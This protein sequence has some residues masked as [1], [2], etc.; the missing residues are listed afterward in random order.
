MKSTDWNNFQNGLKKYTF[1]AQNFVFSDVKGNVGV[2]S[3]GILPYRF[4][5]YRGEMLDGSKGHN[6]TYVPFNNLPQ[7]FESDSGYVYSANQLPVK[8][9]Y[10]INYSWAENFR[11]SR[12]NAILSQTGTL[13]FSEMK[14]IHTDK[15]DNSFFDIIKLYDSISFDNKREEWFQELRSWNG[16][17]SEES[18]IALK[19][20]MLSLSLEHYFS[21]HFKNKD[22]TRTPS[23]HHVIKF[24]GQ[25]KLKLNDEIITTEIIKRAVVDSAI[26]MHEEYV[27]EDMDY[28]NFSPFFLNHIL[29]IPGLGEIV[30][31]KG[32][33][34]NTI[35][36][37][38]YSEH[39]ASMRTI[40]ELS[41]DSIFIETILAGGQ[42]GRVNSPNYSSQ[43]RMWKDGKYNK[44][45]FR[46]TVKNKVN[47]SFK[48]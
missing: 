35:D 15:I 27:L 24:L 5:E 7:H 19:F 44:I 4:K 20:H 45:D 8:S 26:Y 33:N 9:D 23:M 10:Y 30:E 17:M 22:I 11:A 31:D 37:N 14:S 42:S 40:I 3:A 18:T 1:P 36:V 21:E 12:I 25:E 41:E 13:D 16:E 32:G 47:I 29:N 28:G 6:F 46:N 38:G 39:G 34:S 43:T 2:I 48:K